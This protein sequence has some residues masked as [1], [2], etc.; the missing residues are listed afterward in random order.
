MDDEHKQP[1]FRRM[2]SV[3]ASTV[4]LT[5]I[6]VL[7]AMACAVGSGLVGIALVAD[8]NGRADAAAVERDVARQ[9]RDAARVD[10][11]CKEAQRADDGK[12]ALDVLEAMSGLYEAQIRGEAL[13]PLLGPLVD[14]RA[15]I[16]AGRDTKDQVYRDCVA[17]AV[18]AGAARPAPTTTTATSTTG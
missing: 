13:P 2:L 16:V 5:L 18:A 1:K 3:T 17:A 14:A 8:A 6:T 10:A 12:V 9:E 4:I 7:L 11:S 15:Q